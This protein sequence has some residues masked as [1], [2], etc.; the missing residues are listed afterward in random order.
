MKLLLDTQVMLWW[1]LGD[2][3]LR[4]ETRTLMETNDCLLSVASLWEV[5]IKHR[6][7]KLPLDPVRFRDRSLAAGASLLTINDTHAIETG[8]LPDIH[9]DPFDPLIIAQARIENLLVV[10]SDSCWDEYEVSLRR[11]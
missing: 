8:K 7:G 10:S 1:L 9:K 3:R 6:L 4:S 5:A 11:P 2:A